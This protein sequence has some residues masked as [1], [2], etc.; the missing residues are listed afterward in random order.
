M[1]PTRPIVTFTT[2]FGLAD[3]YVAEMKGAVLRMCPEATLVDVSH[4]I[5]PQDVLAGAIALERA[6][7]A[8]PAGTI[9]VAVVDPGVGTDRKLLV[10]RVDGQI[11]LAPDNGLITWTH[12][13]SKQISTHE[14]LWRPSVESARTFHGRDILAPAAGLIAAG[15]GDDV[16]T[17]RLDRPVLL[18]VSIA[19]SLDD[20]VVLHID[21]FGNVITNVPADLVTS[22][23]EI[24]DIGPVRRTYS[25]VAIGD[26][27]ALIGSSGLLEIAIRNQ[28]AAV[29][30]DL[31][32]GNK[33][34]FRK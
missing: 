10:A 20:A 30:L 11:V 25:D 2:D 16:P 17:R 22:T 28:N 7:H 27:V 19:K 15:K 13:R 5:I 18:E 1:P 29:Q 6:V 33:I 3:A 32:V 34:R 21:R 23:T 31:M 14:L 4:V 9:H 26:P 24:P 12:L 8:F